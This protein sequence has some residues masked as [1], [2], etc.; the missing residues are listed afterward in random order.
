MNIYIPANDR[1][2]AL[3]SYL[4]PDG[5]WA[6]VAEFTEYGNWGPCR[7]VPMDGRN[8]GRQVGPPGAACTFGAW[9]PDSKWVYLTTKAGGLYHIWRQRFPDGQPQ[10]FTSGLTEEEGIAMVS[11]TAD[12]L[13]P[14]WGCKAFLHGF[15][16]RVASARFRCLKATPL[17]RVSRRMVKRCATGL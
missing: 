14:Q 5:K 16:T 13:S 11:R 7:V 15:M 1:G 6:L 8:S 4:S 17:I 9:S 3:R 2:M 12:P 10:Q